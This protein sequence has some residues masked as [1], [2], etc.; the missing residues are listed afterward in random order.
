MGPRLFWYTCSFT[1]MA[2]VLAGGA[3]PQEAAKQP[4]KAVDSAPIEID[5]EVTLSEGYT[6]N[7]FSTEN[8]KESDLVTVISPEVGLSLETDRAQFAIG[9]EA[10]IGRYRDHKSENYSDGTLRGEGRVKLSPLTTVFAGGDF[11]WQHED[12]SSP[13][14]VNGSQPTEFREASGFAGVSTRID[15]VTLRIG[16]NLRDFD[17]DDTPTSAGP[18]VNNDDRD[19]LQAEFGTRLGYVL[20]P[21]REI[22]LQG[23]YDSRDY[24]TAVDDAGFQRDSHGLQLSIGAAGRLGNVTGEVFVG[25]LNQNYDDPAFDALTTLGAG[26]EVSWQPA[27]G[28][29]LNA[30]LDR[31]IEETTLSGAS[32]YVATTAGVRLRHRVGADLTANSHLF[33]TQNDYQSAPR[34]DFVTEAGFGLRYHITPNTYVGSDYS[35][36]QR[37]SDVA[38]ADFDTH[39]VFLRLGAELDPA[40]DE[41]AGLARLDGSGFYVGVQGGHGGLATALNGPRGAGGQLT[42]DFGD[43]GLSGGLL[44][45]YRARLGKLELGV[46]LDTETADTAWNHLANRNFS[47]EKKNSVGLSGLVGFRAQNDVLLYGRAGVVGTE[48]ETTYARGGN[49]GQRTNREA[50]LRFGAGA[51][52]PLRGS[53][54]GRM[55]YTVSAY[56]DYDVGAPLG[57][58]DDD[59]FGNTEN[60]ARFALIY[61][62]GQRDPS[63]PAPVDFSGFY[64]GAVFGHGLFGSDNSG[65]RPN[66]AAPA[67]QLRAIR[68]SQGVTGG[69]NAG[70]G[71][72]FGPFYLGAEVEGELSGANWNIERDPTGRIY[73]VDKVGTLGAGLRAGYIVDDAVLIYGRAGVVNGWF[74]TEYAFGGESVSQI[75]SE[76]GLRF[77][78]GVEFPVSEGLRMRLD[79]T[80]TEYSAYSVDYSAGVDRFDNSENLFSL[81]LSYQF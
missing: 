18:S 31:R 68:A 12:R 24:D 71:H 53:L 19:R 10:E 70:Y 37:D 65:P 43:W 17:F 15:D 50:G 22:F 72:A 8:R 3:T 47:T 16:S 9:A 56:P 45:G 20:S 61:R 11:A 49:T 29:R 46:E 7:V 66:A 76:P 77:G 40:Y 5:A 32:S 33:L 4:A 62:L 59:N 6:D 54:S 64:A 39:S 41:G 74:D 27:P 30:V 67:F 58:G 57:G 48:F 69:V 14:D 26:A 81:G 52:F 28:T 38:G 13:D 23:I 2:A 75:D 79:Y 25:V 60:L 73:S 55:E 34:T 1:A 36:E 44:G 78:G 63:A 80:K 42:A 51:E 21:D 35:F